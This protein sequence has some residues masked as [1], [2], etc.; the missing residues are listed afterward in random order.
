MYKGQK[1][2]PGFAECKRQAAPKE[3]NLRPEQWR[4]AATYSC[5]EQAAG[6]W[7]SRCDIWI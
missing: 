7:E 6:Q 2:A 1:D 5:Q 4:T 3:I